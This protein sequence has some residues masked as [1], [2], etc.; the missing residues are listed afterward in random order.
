MCGMS[1]YT[2]EKWISGFGHAETVVLQLI[3]KLL[4]AGHALYVVNFT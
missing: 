2:V 4:D 3:E 1:W